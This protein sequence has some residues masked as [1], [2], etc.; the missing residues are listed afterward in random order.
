[1]RHDEILEIVEQIQFPGAYFC[2]FLKQGLTFLQIQ[3]L[4]GTCNKTNEPMAWRGRKWYISPHSTTSEIVQTAFLALRTAFEHEMREKF[5]F[6]G[7]A[8]LGPHWD[9]NERAQKEEMRA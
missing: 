5:T 1:M 7:A 2:V 3:P 6:R 4:E 9:L 8:V